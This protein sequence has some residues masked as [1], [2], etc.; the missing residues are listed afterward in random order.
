MRRIHGRIVEVLRKE[1]GGGEG[2]R[3]TVEGGRVGFLEEGG[4]QYTSLT[5]KEL[6][7]LRKKYGLPDLIRR[8]D[9]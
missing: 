8:T 3:H 4:K 9:G 6:N 5:N 2:V 7:R 1:F